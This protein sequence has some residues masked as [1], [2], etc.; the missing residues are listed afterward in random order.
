MEA[1][2]IILAAGLGYMWGKSSGKKSG[3]SGMQDNSVSLDNIRRGVKFGWYTATLTMVN[4]QTAVR[5]TGVTN[6]GSTYSD[7]YP[8][9]PSDYETLLQ[10]G[11]ATE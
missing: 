3:T 8:I 6:D 5:L 9:S 2:F 4:G 11:Y 10:E 1:L 7:I